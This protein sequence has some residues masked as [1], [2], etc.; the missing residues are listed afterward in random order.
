MPA[1]LLLV[2]KKSLNFNKNVHLT[3]S[4]ERVHVSCQYSKTCLRQPLRKDKT[5]IL[6]TNGSLMKVKRI[7]DSVILLTCIKR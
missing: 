7:A 3:A 5:K 1:A 6:I 4:I 2:V